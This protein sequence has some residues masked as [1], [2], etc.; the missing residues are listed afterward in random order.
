[1]KNKTKKQQILH[2]NKKCS[3]DIND[4]PYCNDE[5]FYKNSD[6]KLVYYKPDIEIWKNYKLICLVKLIKLV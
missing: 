3:K 5:D 2:I 1:M 6:I 4:C